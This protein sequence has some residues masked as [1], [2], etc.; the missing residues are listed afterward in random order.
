MLGNILSIGNI[1]LDTIQRQVTVDGRPVGISRREF[2]T[3]ELLMRRAGQVV[4]KRAIEDSIYGLAVEVQPNAVEALISRLR[5]RLESFG[6]PL[7]DPHHARRG[8]PAE[9]VGF[10][11][12]I[13]EPS[14]LRRITVRLAIATMVA[15]LVAFGWLYRKASLTAAALRDQTLVEQAQD[16][17]RHIV[18]HPD[19]SVTVDLPAAL[20]EDY[21][22]IRQRLPLRGPRR[23]GE[24][25][26]DVRALYG[27]DAAA[28][29]SPTA[30]LRLSPEW[31][32]RRVFGAAV[33][34]TI[35]GRAFETQVE[36]IASRDRYLAGGSVT[37]E[38]F[39][40]GGWLGVP[41]LIALLAVS[42]LTVRRTLLAAQ[43]PVAAGFGDRAWQ[44]QQP[45]A[46]GWRAAG[47]HAAGARDEFRS[48]PVGSRV[49]A[50]ARVHRERG[51]SS[52]AR[53]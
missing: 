38:F 15:G 32:G 36:E 16:I 29:R 2:A 7:S 1:A 41:F 43:P 23:A 20:A 4:G 33:K 24:P 5:K 51:A 27:V 13:K 14:L 11:P 6:V 17:G 26:S 10:T 3:L 44:N 18:V 19:G 28:G 37:D 49:S 31:P 35:A 9:G 21:G 40:D 46:R 48:R 45:I 42:V 53:P 52:C 39:T 8:L 12:M 50:T 22:R 25:D 30:R 47:D 34:T